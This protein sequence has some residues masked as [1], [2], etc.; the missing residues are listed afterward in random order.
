ME[1]TL[2]TPLF[3]VNENCTLVERVFAN[4]GMNP[5]DVE[6]YLHTSNSDILSPLL[7][8]NMEVGAKMLVTHI[9]QNDVVLIQ[10]D[11]DC[12]GF[13]SAATLI[14]HL[15]RRF[16]GFVQNHIFYRIHTGKQHGITEDTISEAYRLGAKLIICPDASSNDFEQH[17]MLKEDGI[18]VLVIDHHEAD[19]VSENAVI[20]NN[21]LCNYPTKSLSGVGM[22]YKFCSYLDS[23]MGVDDADD[24]LDLVALGLVGDMMDL[25]DFE[26]RHLVVRGIDNIRNPF[27]KEMIKKQAYSIDRAGGLCPFAE[28]FY[29]VPQI[30]A[31][32]RMGDME[33]KLMLFESMLDYRGLEQIPST[34]RGCKGQ[35]E[36]RVEQACRNCTNIK[37]KQTKA[38]DASLNTIEQ[39][40]E[41]EKLLENKILV[42]KL[43]PELATNKNLTGLIANVLM[44]K[45]QRPVLLLSRCERDGKVTWEGSGRGYDKSKFN[46]LRKFLKDS[47]LV[48]LAEG[49]PNALGVGI[50]DEKIDEFIEYSNCALKDFDFSPCY[51]VD[52]IFTASDLRNADIISIADLKS[53]WGQGL[54]E[55]LVAI[56]HINVTKEKVQLMSRD[57]NPTL[58]ITLPNGMSLIKFGSSEAEYES[59]CSE[60]GCV[61]INV[62]GTCGKNEWN[63]AISPQIM[64][65][66]YEIVSTSQYYF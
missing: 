8:D 23:L 59:L 29:I 60:S 56:E 36:T 40:I 5:Q 34:K 35:Y 6:H 61:T 62:V 46:D 3:P 43:E 24:Y 50:E 1:Y 44:A 45:Y 4:R 13:T 52:F 57:K 11:S 33:Q 17:K 20:I 49:H 18:D 22:V 47:G 26:T 19:K 15:N 12:D 53:I 66:D 9:A 21:Q 64:I 38:R 31:T 30:N 37:N 48:F 14:N 63:G 51:K 58:K 41:D 7:I 55:P 28:S 10:V 2:I 16:P 54:E 25:R 39:K 65:E 42:I 32:I 27:L